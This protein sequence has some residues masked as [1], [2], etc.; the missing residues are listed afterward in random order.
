MGRPNSSYQIDPNTWTD[1]GST[2]V[3]LHGGVAPAFWDWA[4]LPASQTL[5]WQEYWYP[6]SSIGIFST[7]T[8]EAAMTLRQ[9]GDSFTVNVHS[10]A[11]RTALESKLFVWD[12][13]TCAQLGQWSFAIGPT[14][15]FS[16]SFP[17]DGRTRDNLSVVY[18]NGAGQTLAAIR[19]INCRAP[20]ARVQPLP[21]FVE[22]TTFTITW[23][24]PEDVTGIGTFQVQ[25]RDGYEGTWTDWL[26]STH[27]ISGTFTGEHG[28]TYLFRARTIAPQQNSWSN[29]EWGQA[30]TTVLTEPAPVLVTSYKKGAWSAMLVLSDTEPIP[31]EVI[32]YN[33][34]ISNTGNLTA[35]AIVT[36]V[37]PV[38]T[39]ALTD[40]LTADSGPPPTYSE[41]NILWTGTVT[42]GESV[43]LGYALVP[44]ATIQRGDRF[45]NTATFA[46]SVL[47]LFTRQVVMVYP[48][49]VWLPIVMRQ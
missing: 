43:R 8:A 23:V 12:R 10:T 49:Q 22:T 25:T 38:G 21:S 16:T 46:G 37:T 24:K 26:S 27:D 7:A 33:V 40:T 45:T 48:W 30:F 13:T 11:A 18:M 15:P 3:E 35:T 36:D 29:E 34:W 4:T 6:V 39:I 44:T 17:S 28:H 47:G 5:T 32:S 41:G 14:A 20:D 42:A 19:P 2:Y 9:D 1:D 31:T